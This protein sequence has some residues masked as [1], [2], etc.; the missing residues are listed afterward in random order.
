MRDLGRAAL[1]RVEELPVGSGKLDV[2]AYLRGSGGAG[3]L[4]GSLDYEH[5][6]TARVS[7][8][9]TAWLGGSFDSRG[10]RSD[11]GALAGLRVR[12]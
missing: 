8:F 10:L 6:A 1:D 11:Y 2:T 3:V 7:T 5:H 12:F 4:G 9:G